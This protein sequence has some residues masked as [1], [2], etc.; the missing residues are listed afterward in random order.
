MSSRVVLQVEAAGPERR[1]L[2]AMGCVQ[3]VQ[4]LPF[5]VRWYRPLFQPRMNWSA[6]GDIQDA[7]GRH[8]FGV[9]GWVVLPE[10]A[11]GSDGWL[12]EPDHP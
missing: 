10:V 8:V 4:L 9:A 12:P 3:P 1:Q 2:P 6:R 7:D 5:H 11:L